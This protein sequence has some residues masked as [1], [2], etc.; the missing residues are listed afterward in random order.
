MEEEGH[1][2][3]STK[4]KSV[5]SAG[6]SISNYKDENGND[7]Q[8]DGDDREDDDAKYARDIQSQ[9]QKVT[10]KKEKTGLTIRG[11]QNKMSEALPNPDELKEILNAARLQRLQQP[12]QKGGVRKGFGKFGGGRIFRKGGGA[13]L[14]EPNFPDL[15]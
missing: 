10:S 7:K 15:E 11:A 13:G 1:D 3:V 4:G 2:D 14:M 12:Q 5:G 9:A 6:G 8:D